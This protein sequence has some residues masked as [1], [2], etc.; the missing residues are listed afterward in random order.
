M[1]YVYSTKELLTLLRS[2]QTEAN[3]ASPFRGLLTLNEEWKPL[4]LTDEQKLLCA[5]ALTPERTL[6][7]GR[8]SSVD[9]ALYL[10]NIGP[11]WYL[12][13]WLEAQDRHVFEAYFDRPRL[14]KF[15]NRNFCGFHRPNFGAFTQLDLRLTSDEFTVWNFIRALQASRSRNGKPKTNQAFLADDLKSSD[16]ALYLHNYLDELG[17][18][19]LSCDV[20]RLMEEKTHDAMD[21]ALK[22]LEE[23]GILTPDI[24]DVTHESAYRLSR[25]AMERLDDG[26]LLDT[27]WYADRTD[28]NR[29]R[30]VLLCLRRDG[31]LAIIPTADGVV[32]RSFESCPWEDLI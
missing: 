4:P 30:E 10:L 5:F 24:T 13:A 28:P 14:L 8:H 16:F 9:G 25:T 17:M 18:E 7:V 15:L 3:S 19:S 32:L 23:K 29:K 27:V 22:G 6:T 2:S 31:V 20:D 1:R 11:M 12:Y 26:M 21:D